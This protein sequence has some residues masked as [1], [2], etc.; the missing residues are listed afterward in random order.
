ML[1]KQLKNA[2]FIVDNSYTIVD[3]AA[4]GWIDKFIPILGDDALKQYPNLNRWFYAINSRPSVTQAREIHT[5]SEFKSV[6]DDE[7]RKALYPK[8]TMHKTPT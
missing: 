2:E 3:M 5:N 7:A 1:D 8:I 6:L 4:R